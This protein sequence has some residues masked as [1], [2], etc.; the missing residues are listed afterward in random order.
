MGILRT[1]IELADSVDALAFLMTDTAQ[2]HVVFRR[3]GEFDAVQKIQILLGTVAGDRE[4]V[5]SR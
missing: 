2:L 5:S 3:A 4:V 1:Q